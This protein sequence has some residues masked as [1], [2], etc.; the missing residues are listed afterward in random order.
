MSRH[1]LEVSELEVCIGRGS[2][3]QRVVDCVSFTLSAGET[4]A[5][6]GESGSGKSLMAKA[7]AGLLPPLAEASGEV[8]FRKQNLLAPDAQSPLGTGI[9]LVFQE[10][11]TALTPVLTVGMQLTEALVFHGLPER[12]EAHRRA[13]EMLDRVGI[14][15]P[16]A[17]MTQYPHEL[18]GG[19]RQRVMIAMMMLEPEVLI[20]DGPRL[21]RCRRK[22]STCCVTAERRIGLMLITHDMG[23]VAEIADNV[24]VL[25]QGSVV[26][27][28]RHTP[29]FTTP[30]QL[31]AGS[32][33]CGT[34]SGAGARSTPGCDDTLHRTAAGRCS[35]SVNPI[36]IWRVVCAISSDARTRQCFTRDQAGGNTG[37]GRGERVGQVDPGSCDCA[38]GRSGQRGGGFRWP[39]A[40]AT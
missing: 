27:R 37:T 12:T 3:P 38:P 22:C 16:A 14:P 39:R 30:E 21:M 19:M 28:A 11:M 17:R 25:R 24:L 10:P 31:Y 23:V 18:S 4:L 5:V 6:V 2:N 35:V 40:I 32:V 20:A 36:D 15:S 33:G 34:A 29:I 9:G 26:E 1:L 8:W 7:V 13:V